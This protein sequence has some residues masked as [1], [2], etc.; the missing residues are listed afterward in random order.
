M[1]CASCQYFSDFTNI[2]MGLHCMNKLNS[3]IKGD[4]KVLKDENYSCTYYKVYNP[5][6]N[7]EWD[8]NKNKSNQK[9]H[10]IG[11]ERIH[12]LYNDKFMVQMVVQPEK[13]EDLS[14]LPD[15]V[16]KNEG[17]TDPVRA[18]LIG[19]IDGNVY[20]AIYTFRGGI[21]EMKYRIISL[22]RID[23]TKNK[24]DINDCE[25]Y[26]SSKSLK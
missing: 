26:K 24:T 19:T 16:E 8:E 12:D 25:F 4:F 15:H 18:K 2:N 22:R 1:N 17:N 14:N 23:N 5:N 7:F 11:F 10:G 13:W 21:G 3:P 6:N 20:T 9:D